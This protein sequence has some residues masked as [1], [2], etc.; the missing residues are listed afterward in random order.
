VHFCW[1]VESLRSEHRNKQLQRQ[2]LFGA[3]QV[4]MLLRQIEMLMA[5]GNST[6]VAC[7]ECGY[8]VPN[9]VHIVSDMH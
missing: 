3:E 9:D 5:Q 7:R 6:P 4:V 2:V 8:I 1:T